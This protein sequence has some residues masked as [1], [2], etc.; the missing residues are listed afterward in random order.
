MKLHASQRA[1]NRDRGGELERAR[2]SVRESAR[3]RSSQ[4]ARESVRE[5]TGP[6]AQQVNTRATEGSR[7][8][9]HGFCELDVFGF[10]TLV[11][12]GVGIGSVV[13]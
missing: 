8:R 12:G 4:R 6:E 2:E 7:R 10:G 5:S 9:N 1:I 3:E 13:R 11:I